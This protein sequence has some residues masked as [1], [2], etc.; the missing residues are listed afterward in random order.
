MGS[1]EERDCALLH[2]S[3]MVLM[4][5]PV[6]DLDYQLSSLVVQFELAA[7]EKPPSR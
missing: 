1:E 7:Y 5:V 2:S 4:L 6:G 3:P